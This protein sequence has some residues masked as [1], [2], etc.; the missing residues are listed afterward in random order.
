[1]KRMINSIAIAAVFLSIV[2]SLLGKEVL[3]SLA[4]S[5][6]SG[7]PSK[8][9]G[10]ITGR[11]FGETAMDRAWS[12]AT[13]Y[14]N[15]DNSVLQS[16]SLRG[17]LY[18]QG[19][20]GH[21]DTGHFELADRVTKSNDQSYWGNDIEIRLAR[22]GFK[23]QW[24][25]SFN[26]AG[27]FNLDP[28]L[29][30]DVYENLHDLHISYAA[31]PLLHVTAGKMRVKIT[32]ESEI[33]SN[34]I[35][36]IER[37]MLSN[38]FF[39]GEL[40]GVLFHGDFSDGWSYEAGYFDNQRER[41]FAT[42][43]GGEIFLAKLAYDYSSMAGLKLAKA[44]MHYLHN[45]QPNFAGSNG[46]SPKFSDSFVLTNELSQG[47]LRLITE[48]LFG[49]GA[50]AQSDVMGFTFLPSYFIADRLQLVTR[51]HYAKSDGNDGLSLP[52][53]YETLA[54]LSIANKKGDE[55]TSAYVGLNYYINGDKLKL[56]S[57]LEYATMTAHVARPD[58]DGYTWFNG[59]RFS[60]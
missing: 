57:G 32:R 8:A 24:F 23:S 42:F 41:E 27:M 2:S 53:R 18:L 12:A 47:R 59:I 58:Y 35:L 20:D 40:T 44:G 17:G 5:I 51:F 1:M 11:L 31:S 16:F 3:E 52:S 49:A 34:S 48:A 7:S 14:M 39:P 9:K 37:T 30:P 6:E 54:P 50:A 36:T 15:E 28:N 21:S 4:P 55:Y 33:P 26:F 45:T 25:R 43:D 19:A 56:M 29:V 38:A 22:L 13:L 46:T 10:L 60:F